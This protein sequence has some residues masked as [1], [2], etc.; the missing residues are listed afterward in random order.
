MKKKQHRLFSV[1]GIALADILA[2]GVAVILILIILSLIVKQQEEEKQVQQSRQMQ[3]IMAQDI[4][5]KI[6]VNDLP[7]SPPA[8]LH[9]YNHKRRKNAPIIEFYDNFIRIVDKGVGTDILN[10]I[11]SK[12]QLLEKNN[13]LEKFL[14]SLNPAQ[15][16]NVRADVFSVSLYYLVL[17]IFK[18]NKLAIHHWHYLGENMAKEAIK[19]QKKNKNIKFIPF[20]NVNNKNKEKSITKNNTSIPKNITFDGQRSAQIPFDENIP[21]DIDD[22]E[23]NDKLS[24]FDAM[25]ESFSKKRGQNKEQGFGTK[26]LKI[27]IAGSSNP[28]NISFKENFVKLNST[29]MSYKEFMLYFLYTY[30]EQVQKR[31]NENK[32]YDITIKDIINKMQLWLQ[33]PQKYLNKS[34]RLQVLSLLRKI[35]KDKVSADEKINTY[36]ITKENNVMLLKTNDLLDSVGLFYPH[37]NTNYIF[38]KNIFTFKLHPFDILFAGNPIKITNKNIIL[39]PANN[40][41][42][43]RN[44]KVIAVIDKKMEDINIGYVY[45]KKGTTTFHM[46]FLEN[47]IRINNVEM[48]NDY[49]EKKD[50]LLNIHWWLY[51]TL[52]I[53]FVLLFLIRKTKR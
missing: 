40:I 25:T 1:V 53:L 9:D 22:I 20:K 7:T 15:R 44:F 16:N 51:L 43:K 13:Q 37:E 33:N 30:L 21:P 27:T 49:V 29:D 11:I 47:D 34:Y 41:Y 6:I 23:K 8:I 36:H 3:V 38:K 4:L 14:Q 39:S 17:S 35:K 12:A 5:N 42:N 19:N 18:E 28:A 26:N 31:Q 10:L 52:F 2:N 32:F 24:I 50:Y 48:D 46:P 45:V